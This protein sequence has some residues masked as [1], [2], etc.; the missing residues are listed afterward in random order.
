MAIE[1]KTATD[2]SLHETKR[3]WKWGFSDKTGW[4]WLQMLIQLLAALAIPIAIA[5]GTQWFSYQQS[6]IS[7]ANSAQQH[8]F[9]QQA[10]LDQQREATLKTYLDDMANLLLSNKLRESQ[11]RDEVRNVARARTLTALRRLDP[12]RKGALL[13]FLYES[14]LITWH[15]LT[16]APLPNADA[17]PLV[18]LDK[19][20]L[21][22]ADL[23]G[24]FMANADLHNTDLSNADLSNSVLPY[25]NLSQSTMHKVNLSGAVLHGDDL[26]KVDLN[27][28]NL[29]GALLNCDLLSVPP[30]GVLDRSKLL[31]CPNLD[32]ADLSGAN[33]NGTHLQGVDL[34]KVNL[35]QANLSGALIRCK[36]LQVDSTHRRSYCTNL[37][38][39]NLSGADLSGADLSGA[40]LKGATV[41]KKQLAKAKSLHGTI[42]PDGSIHL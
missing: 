2:V 30:K 33:L 29:S 4:D 15:N 6:Q 20:D 36:S 37:S 10:A 27:G 28:A 25:A 21:S 8:L 31:M 39:V 40:N 12:N 23:S 1:D 17:F 26:T 5:V 9:D 24:V 32:G 18:S 41:T 11:P 19:A 14:D 16:S 22:E 35:T 42:M 7:E 13:R 38:G 3:T 34:T